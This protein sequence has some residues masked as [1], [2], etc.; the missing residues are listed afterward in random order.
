[1]DYQR[2]RTELLTPLQSVP[3]APAGWTYTG[4]SDQ[5][6]A[7]KLNDPNGGRTRNRTNVTKNEIIRNIRNADYPTTSANDQ[8]KW[9]KLNLLLSTDTIDASSTNVRDTFTAIFTGTTTLTTLNTLATE[10][11]SRTDELGLGQ[12]TAGDVGIARAGGG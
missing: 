11:V 12:V 1:M 10:P 9:N 8:I 6:A 2:L 5:A 7:D 3:P 4:L